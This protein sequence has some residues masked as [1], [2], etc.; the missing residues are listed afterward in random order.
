[1]PVTDLRLPP[2]ASRLRDVIALIVEPIWDLIGIPDGHDRRLDDLTPGQRG[3]YGLQVM[4]AE[5]DNGGFDQYFWNSTGS[6][7]SEAT[8]GARLI[9][10]PPWIDLLEEASTL[11]GDPY[12]RHRAERLGRLDVLR[13]AGRERLAS[14]DDR[15]YAL[16]RDPDTDLSRLI[17][18]MVPDRRSD[19]FD[20]SMPFSLRAERLVRMAHALISAERDR[21]LDGAEQLL[22][23]AVEISDEDTPSHRRGLSLLSQLP[24]LRS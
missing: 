15:A 18:L 13:A 14:L 6:L 16:S 7:H 1:M 23:R 5:V 8:E 17:R 4:L 20:D 24:D 19:F 22:R 12:P 3:V 2:D 21:D 11:V 10:A 9:G